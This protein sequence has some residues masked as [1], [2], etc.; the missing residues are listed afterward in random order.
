MNSVKNAIVTMI[1]LAVGYGAY[2]VLTSPA[3]TDSIDELAE[4]AAWDAPEVIA[5][6]QVRTTLSETGDNAL[7][8]PDVSVPSAEVPSAEFPSTEVQSGTVEMEPGYA[9]LPEAVSGSAT[10]DDSSSAAIAEPPELS[11]LDDNTYPTTSAPELPLDGVSTSV[12]PANATRQESGFEATWQSVQEDLGQELLGNALMSLSA[13]YESPLLSWS[14]RERAQQLLDQLAGTVIYSNQSY[15]EPPHIIENG[16]TFASIAQTHHI[17]AVFLARINGSD[18]SDALS[19]GDTVKV[20]KGP[21]RAEIN[22]Q[23]GYLTL[24]L[25]RHYAGRFQARF[26][27]DLPDGE[28]TFE[29]ASIE[30]NQQFVDSQARQPLDV[31]NTTGGK[32]IG[33]QDDMRLGGDRVGIHVDMG[34][35]AVGCIGVSAVDIDD[36]SVILSIGSRITVMR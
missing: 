26:G 12:Q 15:V 3:P 7:A 22:R 30:T 11:P 23:Q 31:Q 1:L 2:V 17:P 13:W 36:L 35:P 18:P 27:A 9:P 21:F 32:W 29:V 4:A 6:D 5:P 20:L 8:V 14:D 33:L 28:N 10:F 25:G 34:D 19:P 24:F 16:E